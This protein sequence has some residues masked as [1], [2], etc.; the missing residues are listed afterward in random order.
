MKQTFTYHACLIPRYAAKVTGTAPDLS[1]EAF[2]NQRY[3][4]A[5]YALLDSIDKK[6][7]TCPDT[8]GNEYTVCHGPLTIYIKLDQGKLHISAPFLK[9]SDRNRMAMMRQIAAINFNDL[10]LARISLREKQLYFDYSC[11][12]AFSH[13][14]KVYQILEEICL[15]G[16]R[17]DYEF[18]SQFHAERILLPH[19]NPYPVKVVDYIYHVIQESIRECLHYLKHFEKTRHFDDM[20]HMISITLLK[21]VYVSHPQGKLSHTL[22]KAI[23]EMHRDIPLSVIIAH[24]KQTLEDLL[25]VPK[26]NIAES[27]YSVE[28][29]IPEKPYIYTSGIREKFHRLYKQAAAQ[30]EA[31]DYKDLCLQ[32][33]Y[34]FYES[35]NNYLLPE[36][37][38]TIL[39]TA[40]HKTSSQPWQTS[41]FILYDALETLLNYPV[42]STSQESIVAA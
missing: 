41:A 20:W 8:Q 2:E 5:L 10:D 6:L 3:E 40:L 35:Y 25:E 38:D 32:I 11:P 27:L 37:V 22:Q 9:L 39:Q 30:L 26:E 33:T 21:M 17:Y 34:K 12:V 18:H 1:V 28:T 15:T 42:K 14:R 16:S 31:G 24:G 7:T 36:E 23:R 19:F 29:I 13:P 4:E